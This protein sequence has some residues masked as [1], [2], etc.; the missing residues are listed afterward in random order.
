MEAATETTPP[1]EVLVVNPPV[2]VVPG[3]NTF[4]PY[5]SETAPV[6]LITAIAPNNPAIE[7]IPESVSF[8]GADGQSPF[9]DGS[10][11]E[12]GV[13]SGILLTTGSG[14]PA[15]TN[16]VPDFGVGY[17][18]NNGDAELQAV[19]DSAF[20]GSGPVDDVNSLGFSFNVTD[21]DVKSV[22]F[23]LVFGSDEFPEFSNSEFVDIGAVFVNGQNVGLFNNDPNQPLSI[24]DGNLE[25]GNFQNNNAENPLPIEYDGVSSV[26]TVVAPVQQ[27]ENTIRFGIADTGDT[28]FD[29]GLFIS[30]LTPTVIDGGGTSSGVLLNITGT[31]EADELIGDEND[32]FL[33]L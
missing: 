18:V 23:D 16:T 20:E 19:A 8:V 13:D 9:Y 15:L 11:T 2:T 6:D 32:Q 22:S 33:K 30:N 14:N 12:L 21:R 1:D 4:R 29:S 17:G 28:A 26:L 7:I 27:G 10:L 25:L 31:E 3:E 5:T 24:I